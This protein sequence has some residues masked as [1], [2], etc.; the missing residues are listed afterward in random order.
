MPDDATLG[1]LR[2]IVGDV[3][4]VPMGVGSNRLYAVGDLVLRVFHDA[5]RLAGDPWY[6]PEHE[7]RVLG[8]LADTPVPAPVPIAA[9]L[10][11]PEPALL[12][13]RVPGT[14]E[15]PADAAVLLDR[16]AELLAGIHAVDPGTVVSTR[17]APYYAPA[18]RS[19]PTWT[20]RPHVWQRMITVL[21]GAPPAGPTGF[22]HRD[23]HAG[24]LLWTG[25][26]IGGVVDWSTGCVGPLGI[27]VARFRLNLALTHG[28]AVAE[29]FVAAYAK[30]AG[31]EDVHHPYWD[32][33]DAADLLVDWSE[34]EG[35][36]ELVAWQR[37]EAWVGRAVRGAAKT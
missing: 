23:F 20:T 27:D 6:R 22:I 34:P 9:L 15:P 26:E 28:V 24:Q 3:D 32:L 14:P 21:D 13:T 12:T 5:D 17:Y 18:G 4:V 11:G 7:A 1:R 25:D 19:V 10:D 8:L 36:D 29:D 30:A 31:R 33:L 2:E 35:G 16:A 37:F